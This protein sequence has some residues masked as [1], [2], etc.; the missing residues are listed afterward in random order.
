MQ[1]ANIKYNDPHLS[2]SRDHLRN[3]DRLQR[4][5]QNLGE[6]LLA[7]ARKWEK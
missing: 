5:A 7:I 4:D 2:E 1:T 3:I 6:E